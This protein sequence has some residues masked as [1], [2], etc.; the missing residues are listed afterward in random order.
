M[1]K[2]ILGNTKQY[3]RAKIESP[4]VLTVLEKALF[5]GN[6]LLIE[7]IKRTVGPILDPYYLNSFYY[8]DSIKVVKIA[9]IA[10]SY[11]E[12]FYLYLFT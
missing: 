3:L 1:D 8:Q 9:D 5:L 6:D 7:D 12:S 10:K 2:K 11:E 4:D